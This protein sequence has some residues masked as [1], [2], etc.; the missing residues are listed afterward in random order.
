ML[1]HSFHIGSVQIRNRA[2][3]APM[4]GISDLPFR[5]LAWRYGA[6]LVVT[7]MVASREL[8]CNRKESWI[9]LKGDGISPHVVQLAG[10]EAKWM[11]EAAIIAEARGADVIDINMGCPAKKVTGGYSG[12]AL[13]RNPDHA[14][15]LI[16]ATVSAVKVP[17]TVK[18]RLGWDEGSINAPMLASRAESAGAQMITVHGRTR[19]QFYKG[20][21]DWQAIRAVR[22]EISV[23]LVANGDVETAS[24][25]KAIL[26][27]SGADAVMI[28][29]SAQGRPWLVGELA[30][31]K[32][33]P[34]TQTEIL[35]FVLEHYAMNLE[36]HGAEI[37]LRHF[38]KHLGW[39]LQRHVTQCCGDLKAQIM[40][41]NETAE[42]VEL[43]TRAFLSGKEP[44][45][46]D[47]VAA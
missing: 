24:D 19:S 3:L 1:E 35:E 7:E 29:R 4:S 9:R 2:I 45:K 37:G 28:G 14:L 5:R 42:V 39:Y 26:T 23:P 33:A 13:M 16:E 44:S 6:G 21:A 38:R 8:L 12:S 20:K 40:T 15:E 11:H 25:V 30:G 27:A 36:H 41:S 34:R 10:C 32:S 43:L 47:R 18:M 22:E 31:H 17:V 46:T